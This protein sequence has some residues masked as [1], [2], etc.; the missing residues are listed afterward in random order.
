[1]T[2]ARDLIKSAL[3]KISQLGIGEELD[4]DEANDAL[5]TLNAML[6]SFSVEGPLIYFIDN[7]TFSL[8]SGIG[9]YTIGASGD[10]NTTI[11]YE[12]VNAYVSQGDTDY[13]LT[14]YGR[15]QFSQITQKNLSNIPSVYFFD[16]NY[17]LAKLHIYEL[18]SGGFTITLDSKKRLTGF[19]TLDTVFAMPPEFKSMIEYNLAVW[20][21]PEYD[22]EAPISVKQIAERT[23]SAIE[24]Q[25]G[26]NQWPVSKID[27]PSSGYQG[28]DFN[29]Y[30]G[31]GSP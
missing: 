2:T 1:M 23:Y 24:S 22:R 18:P 31:T 13:Q 14:K 16:N 30:E 27:A 4:A 3:R 8:S 19:D 6:S 25:T 29:I 5:G 12:I 7:E 15:K 17:P 9:E 10:F 26:R 20:I 28:G 11:P 21:A